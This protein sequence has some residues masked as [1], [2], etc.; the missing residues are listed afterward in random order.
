MV[1]LLPWLPVLLGF[2]LPVLLAA[3]GAP[4]LGWKD[5]ASGLGE[6]LQRGVLLCCRP[7]LVHLCV[8]RRLMQ[9][10]GTLS[11]LGGAGTAHA[12]CW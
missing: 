2:D 3:A 4:G 9:L 6:G 10:E 5:A 7:A 1:L 12:T 8:Q 11:G